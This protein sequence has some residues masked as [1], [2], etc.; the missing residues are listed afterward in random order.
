MKGTADMESDELKSSPELEPLAAALP[1]Y[2]PPAVVT[3]TDEELLAALGPAR[4][5]GTYGV[6]Q[7]P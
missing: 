4:A 3:Y 5:G 7:I 6:F 2:E 1:P